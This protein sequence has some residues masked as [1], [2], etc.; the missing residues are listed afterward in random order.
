MIVL[1][2]LAAL[3]LLLG[4]LSLLRIGG[5]V[6]YNRHGLFVWAKLGP[7]TMQVFPW[8]RQS[9]RK[10]TRA[11]KEASNPSPAPEKPKEKK[12][13]PSMEERIGGALEYAQT[14]VPIAVEAAGRFYHKLR[15]D[16]LY[17]EVTMGSP[18]PA[19]AALAYGRASGVLAALWGPLTQAFHVVDGKAKV[20]VDFDGGGS[21][22]YGSATLS[23]RIHQALWLG[24]LY[25]TKALRTFLRIRKGTSLPKQQRKAA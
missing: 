15:M 9:K 25:G 24:L 3:F 7:V 5:R 12:S 11:K 8:K 4:L 16:T 23:I 10:H 19:D 14:L 1:Y 21:R 18:D 17:L 2:V 22:V 13:E 20:Q 6:E